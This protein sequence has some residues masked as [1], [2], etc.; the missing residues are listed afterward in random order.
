MNTTNHAH[1][2]PWE[3]GEDQYL[4]K[5]RNRLSPREMSKFLGRSKNAVMD[6]MSKLRAWHERESAGPD[7]QIVADEVV[8][9]LTRHVSAGRLC[10][11]EALRRM[12]RLRRELAQPDAVI[13]SRSRWSVAHWVE[14]ISP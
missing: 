4:W 13:L 14:H 3:E 10:K 8:K 11:S 7:R 5:N 9:E 2:R 6:R 12:A 1:K